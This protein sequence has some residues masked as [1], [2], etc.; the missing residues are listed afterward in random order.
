MPTFTATVFTL[1]GV[2]D[3]EVPTVVAV[4]ADVPPAAFTA[5]AVVAGAWVTGGSVVGT[6][7]GTTATRGDDARP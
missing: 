3:F 2:D 6:N 1:C 5:G 7:S 4:V